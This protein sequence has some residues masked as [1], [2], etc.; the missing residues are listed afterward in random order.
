MPVELKPLRY[1]EEMADKV[2]AT[3]LKVIEGDVVGDDT[4]FEWEPYA[5][6]TG[7]WTIWCGDMARR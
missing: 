3:G 7:R 5:G 2:M 1:L 4:Y 6:R